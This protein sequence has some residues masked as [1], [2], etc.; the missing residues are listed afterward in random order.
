MPRHECSPQGWA[1]LTPFTSSFMATHRHPYEATY[2]LL[3]AGRTIH[4]L[5]GGIA[6]QTVSARKQTSQPGEVVE[7]TT[8]PP[9]DLFDGDEL[10][11]KRQTASGARGLSWHTVQGAAS[12]S[13]VHRGSV[14][15]ARCCGGNLNTARGEDPQQC[16]LDCG[17]LGLA[18]QVC[19][20]GSRWLLSEP[21]CRRPGH[22]SS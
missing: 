7:H 11:G 1:R 14:P 10:Q 13:P 3:T 20:A 18:Y 19:C 2:R 8:G 9:V 5:R 22:S 6:V 12:W 16:L 4:G 15:S 21:A 17:Y